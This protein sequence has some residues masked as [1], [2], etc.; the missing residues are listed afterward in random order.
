MAA[1]FLLHR[2]NNELGLLGMRADRLRSLIGSTDSE[3]LE[4]ITGIERTARNLAELTRALEVLKKG[5]T[6]EKLEINSLLYEVWENLVHDG[7]CDG[8]QID[9]DLDPEIIPEIGANRGLLA[10]A[11][12]LVL[13][14]AL[15]A[16]D[17][18]RGHLRICTRHIVDDSEIVV[19]I[20]D[21]GKGIPPQVLERLFI[22][23]VASTKDDPARM[24]HG[25]GLWLVG[26]ILTRL[27]GSIQILRTGFGQGTIVQITLPVTA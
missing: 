4:Y 15:E 22:Q 5:A 20:E 9:W 19:E 13:E 1:A 10:E 12:R 3:A 23:P 7:K 24:G 21:N 17:H 6:P 25:T 27:R 16:N 18:Q 8:A 14:N 11:F 26:L 2:I